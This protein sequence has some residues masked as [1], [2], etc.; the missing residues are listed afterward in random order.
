MRRLGAPVVSPDGK[1]AVLNVVE[2]AYDPKDERD[3]LWLISL[4][5]DAEPR[6]LTASR[7]VESGVEWSPDAR[8]VAFSSQRE[9]D[10]APQIY[11][12]DLS[13][14]GDA[15]RLT[16]LPLGAR[17]PHWSPDG[18]KLLFTSYVLPPGSADGA[19]G[20]DAKS[21]VQVFEHVVP[22]NENGSLGQPRAHLFVADLG[23]SLSSRDLFSGTKLIQDA[24]FSGVWSADEEKLGATWVPDARAIVFVGQVRAA[25][26]PDARPA[27]QLFLVNLEGGE[28]ERLTHDSDAYELPIFSPDGRKIVVIDTPADRGFQ[29]SQKK[30]LRFPWP[31]DV[32]QRADL[33]EKFEGAAE[34]PVFSRDGNKVY[35]TS[36][37]AGLG[38]IFGVPLDSGSVKPELDGPNGVVT[39]LTRGGWGDQFRL[40]GLWESAFSPPEVYEFKTEEGKLTAVRLTHF[41]QNR[42]A[43]LDLFPVEHFWFQS[44]HGDHLHSLIVRPANFDPAKKYPVLAIV[45][46]G[47]HEM[48]RD[49]FGISLNYHLL[50]GTDYVLVPR[51]MWVRLDSAKP[52]LAAF[53]ETRRKVRRVT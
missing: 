24:S 51:I 4:A 39:Q 34:S 49:R 2:P 32:A 7:A 15:E 18:K 27:T 46:S 31:F 33:T 13:A 28:P 12:L 26:D 17:A 41:N 45:H 19:S 52:L 50:A 10:H 23:A 9:D 3:D 11:I 53:K 30:L 35:F 47:P 6:R 40:V 38:K 16:Q 44:S 8:K 20:R 25:S 22:E 14:G 37:Q 5:T 1:W 36:E 21:R 43:S 29:F 48:A 42:A